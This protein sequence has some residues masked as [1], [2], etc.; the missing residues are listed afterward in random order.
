MQTQTIHLEPGS[1]HSHD[2]VRYVWEGEQVRVTADI[3]STDLLRIEVKAH[4]VSPSCLLLFLKA[5]ICIISANPPVLNSANLRLISCG[6]SAHQQPPCGQQ[7]VSQACLSLLPLP[8]TSPRPLET[9]PPL[10]CEYRFI[11]AWFILSRVALMR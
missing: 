6:S 9:L 11:L 3:T 2:L 5:N 7:A 10:S 8:F 4:Q 1:V